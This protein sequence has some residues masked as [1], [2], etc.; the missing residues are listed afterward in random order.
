MK[1]QKKN[2]LRIIW[3]FFGFLAM[4]IGA[5]GVVLPVLPTE[6]CG[7]P[8]YDFEDKI[9]SAHSGFLYAD[10]GISG[11]AECVRQGVYPF[12]DPVQIRVFLYKDTHDSG[13]ADQYA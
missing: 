2:P 12:S 5:A 6:F 9:Q 10:P 3:L 4:G 1:N 13:G 11:N 8:L 7:E